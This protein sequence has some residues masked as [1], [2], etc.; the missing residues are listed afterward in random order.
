M[1]RWIF[2]Q[3]FSNYNLCYYSITEQ[4]H[5]WFSPGQTTSHYFLQ[6]HVIVYYCCVVGIYCFLLFCEIALC[7]ACKTSV[8]H[9]L[10]PRLSLTH[11]ICLLLFLSKKNRH[12]RNI[13]CIYFFLFICG[14][15]KCL[16]HLQCVWS[17]E[18]VDALCSCCS[19][20]KHLEWWPAALY[21]AGRSGLM[22]LKESRILRIE[23]NTLFP[24]YA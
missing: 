9:V 24:I 14:C 22:L 7:T 1:V 15:P 10:N 20:Q 8:F 19:L 13:V 18:K 23:L 5:G 2:T 4:P 3:K 16:S 6:L 17:N 11:T 12:G 21:E